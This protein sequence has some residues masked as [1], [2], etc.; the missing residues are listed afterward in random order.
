MTIQKIA[1]VVAALVASLTIAC[2]AAPSSGSSPTPTASPVATATPTAPTTAPTATP[3]AAPEAAYLDDRSSA[4]Q[5]IR[6]YY[7]A[8]S[9]RQY[10]RAYWYWEASTTLPPYD[11]FARGFTDTTSAQVEL[12]TVGG[13]PGAGQL[14]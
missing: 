9:K 14:Y 8:V 1:P 4:E 11:T 12:G 6:S 13:S 3:T 2:A 10:L 7:D 5:L